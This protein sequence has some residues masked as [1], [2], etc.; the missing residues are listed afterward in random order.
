MDFS[1]VR[2]FSYDSF[3]YP[4]DADSLQVN[5]QTGSDVLSVRLVY[6]DPFKGKLDGGKWSWE[7]SRADMESR[8]LPGAL[9]WSA[10]VRP[11]FKRCKYYFEIRADDGTWLF[12]EDGFY[13]SEGED[14]PVEASPFIFPW[15][16]ESDIVS[17]PKWAEETVWYQIFPS[18]FCRGGDGGG[19]FLP[20]ADS[21][22]AVRNE[23]R[24][25]GNLLGIIDRLG[26]LEEL[27]ING[28]YINPINLSVSQHKYDTADYLTI[29]PEFG[30][31]AI[32]RRLVD[33]A[34]ARGMRVMLD[35]VFNHCGWE[36]FAW[37]DVIKNGEKSRYAGWFM[38]N[39]YGFEKTPC[40]NAERG[41]YFSFAF[42]D[43]MPKLNTNNP[44]V[45]EYF[46]SVCEKWARDYGI[47]AIRLDVANELS[48]TFCR[49]LRERLLSV[50][51]DFFIAGE[52]WNDSTPWL[53]GA[54]FDSVIN[55]PL[56]SA[57][58]RFASDPEKDVRFLEAELNRCLVRYTRQTVR[59][60]INQMDSHDTMRLVT[61]MDGDK[62]MAL[63]QFALILSLPGATC[64]YY[65][66]EI[67][68]PGGEDPDCRRCM[69]WKE[70]E[71][72]AFDDVLDFM[73]ALVRL[74]RDSPALKS[75]ELSFRFLQN[76]LNGRRR[77]VI[78]EKRDESSGEHVE[79]LFNFGRAPFAVSSC[80]VVGSADIALSRRLEGGLLLPGGF[81]VVRRR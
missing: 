23:E 32:L 73:R 42:A 31:G 66:T 69:P 13:R 19:D 47:D 1:A 38:V 68:L 58:W 7:R 50:K 22:H 11:E 15:M 26:Y 65:G 44:E 75:D 20:W 81:A 53:R 55:Y 10:T 74:R 2:H 3:C 27:G 34:H 17:P 62:D 67:L 12:F 63:L 80:G 33:E 57:I 52:I 25:G 59:V 43:R 48:H 21:S 35:G 28:L 79:C 56:R 9:F 37:Q 60:L 49:A 24:Y 77:V 6:G 45:R 16:N 51:K 29:D 72:G 64:M 41:A 18:R 76:D 40:D 4:L 61:R 30:T 8:R 5:V 46:C 14:V 78:L 71:E 39:D 70:I 54:E 36:F